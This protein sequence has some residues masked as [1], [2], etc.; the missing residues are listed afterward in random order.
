[1]P[2]SGSAKLAVLRSAPFPII[3]ELG[4]DRCA[5]LD[6]L[7]RGE[8]PALDLCRKLVA[9]GHDPAT[10]MHVFRQGALALRIRTIGEGAKLRV[11]T[12]AAGAPVF[13]KAAVTLAAAPPVAPTAPA[14]PTEPPDK[15]AAPTRKRHQGMKL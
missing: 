14:A 5:K 9:A 11:T 8:A 15:I 3:A 13:R 1:M 6:L 4:N 7:G 12:N 10:P 2:V